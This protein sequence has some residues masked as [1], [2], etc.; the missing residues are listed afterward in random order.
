MRE[1]RFRNQAMQTKVTF[2]KGLMAVVVMFKHR[3]I[4]LTKTFQFGYFSNN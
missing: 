2:L 4:N 1:P 3:W